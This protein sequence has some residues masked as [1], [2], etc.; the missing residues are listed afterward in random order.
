MRQPIMVGIVVVLAI[1]FGFA[2][3]TAPPAAQVTNGH[4]SI[5][6]QATACVNCSV[7]RLDSDVTVYRTIHAKGSACPAGWTSLK[8]FFTE[9]DLNTKDACRNP[10]PEH[11]TYDMDYLLAG[12]SFPAMTITVAR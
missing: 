3:S 11:A 8:A 10:H 5:D 2:C 9:S 7:A 6:G 12:E 4:Q 1:A